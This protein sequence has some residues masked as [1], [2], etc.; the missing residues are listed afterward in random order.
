MK[1]GVAVVSPSAA[2]KSAGTLATNWGVVN[3]RKYLRVE[4]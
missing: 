4:D 2:I 1:Y 3:A